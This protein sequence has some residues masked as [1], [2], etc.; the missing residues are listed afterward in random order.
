VLD[1]RLSRCPRHDFNT[2][3]A[4]GE[5]RGEVVDVPLCPAKDL[6]ERE[7]VDQGDTQA[8]GWSVFW[9]LESIQCG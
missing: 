1:P 4:S 3:A 5:R 6:R 9:L 2:V 7:S 8:P